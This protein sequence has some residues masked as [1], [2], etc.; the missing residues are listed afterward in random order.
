[1]AN[2]NFDI[3]TIAFLVKMTPTLVE[4][5]HK[6]YTSYDMVPSRAEE[7]KSFLKGSQYSKKERSGGTRDD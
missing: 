3:N 6:L 7:L 5:Y 1:L 4:E 2:E